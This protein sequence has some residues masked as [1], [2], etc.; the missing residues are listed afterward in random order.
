MKRT[1][2]VLGLVGLVG[3]FL[4]MVL[5]FS[6]FDARDGNWLRVM[7]VIAAFAVPAA[8]ALADKVSVGARLLAAGCFGYALWMF[9]ARG[10]FDLVVHGSI[11]GIAM[12]LAA[13]LGLIVSLASLS[14]DTNA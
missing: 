1:I 7:S 8:L 9:G 14:E 4:P 13:V 5:G 2:S 6:L 11:G 12:G 10:V 3:C